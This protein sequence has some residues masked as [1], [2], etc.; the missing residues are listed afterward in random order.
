MIATRLVHFQLIRTRLKSQHQLL[1]RLGVLVHYQI[2]VFGFVLT[3]ESHAKQ[4]R[5]NAIDVSLLSGEVSFKILGQ[6]IVNS[7]LRVAGCR[8]PHIALH[9]VQKAQN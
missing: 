7:L 3:T 2:Y 6:S 9:A 1:L 8:G 4:E 5:Q